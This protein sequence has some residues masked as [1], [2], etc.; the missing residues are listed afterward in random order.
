MKKTVKTFLVCT[1]IFLRNSSSRAASGV[2]G[3]LEFWQNHNR[4]KS[5][6]TSQCIAESQISDSL[7]YSGTDDYEKGDKK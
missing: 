3:P 1:G 5:T 4:Y 7:C 6:E 2:C